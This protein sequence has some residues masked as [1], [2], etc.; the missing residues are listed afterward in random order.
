MGYGL[1]L[2]YP[3]YTMFYERGITSQYTHY[4]G[5]AWIASP[6]KLTKRHPPV[7]SVESKN[8]YP[9]M[10]GGSTLLQVDL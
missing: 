4:F 2:S 7:I 6:S 10:Q 8:N 1:L 9:S 5:L 3:H